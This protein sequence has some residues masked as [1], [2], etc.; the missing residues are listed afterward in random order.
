MNENERPGPGEGR[1]KHGYQN[2][3]N[4]DDGQGGQPYANQDAALGPTTAD[5]AEAGN[6]GEASGRNLE[7][8]EAM[9]QKP[10]QGTERE[11]PRNT[12]S[13]EGE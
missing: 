1:A 7:E 13:G 11:A 9:K 3:V 4:W 5:E 6:R 2:E 8:M 10:D 12:R